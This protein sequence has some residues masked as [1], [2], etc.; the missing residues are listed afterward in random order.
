MEEP[1]VTSSSAIS[2]NTYLWNCPFLSSVTLLRNDASAK[3]LKLT[4][5]IPYSY[6]LLLEY[7][8]VPVE[9]TQLDS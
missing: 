1:R 2:P 3:A 7:K 9:M 4:L 8:D 5:R 6:L